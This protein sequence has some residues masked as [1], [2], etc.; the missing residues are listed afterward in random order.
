ML[1]HLSM[2]RKSIVIIIYILVVF[3]MSLFLL[4][5]VTKSTDNQKSMLKE[6]LS[7]TANYCE[8]LNSAAFHYFCNEE[9]EEVH[10]KYPEY[11]RWQDKGKRH[12][13]DRQF[14]HFIYEYQILKKDDTVQEKR[15]LIEENGEKKH[16][17]KAKLAT[18]FAYSYRSF[19]GPISLAGKKNQRHYR[20]TILEHIARPG[21]DI[22][23]IEA[24]P[25]HKSA[26]N[27]NHGK[28]WVHSKTGSV[29]RIEVD[30]KSIP[31]YSD[32]QTFARK[33]G[34]TAE[35]KVNHYYDMLRKGLRYPSKTE[36]IESYYGGANLQRKFENGRY[37]RSHT[38]FQ[39]KNY[40]FFDVQVEYRLEK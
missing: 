38:T 2:K 9:I 24:K 27:R 20:Y 4:N 36:F 10:N 28:L 19:Y 6:V 34:A 5:P 29:L 7:K 26:K 16:L 39:Y 23:V 15:V 1:L 17:E 30:E 11:R 22:L 14:N 13:A 32:M 3:G 12:A 37:V 25:K 33:Y 8:R 21:G 40:S 31:G 18:R 35:L